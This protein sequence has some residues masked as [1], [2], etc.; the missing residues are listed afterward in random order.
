MSPIQSLF[1]S[2]KFLLLLLDTLIAA[3]LYFGGRYLA[4]AAVEELTFLI[5]ILQPV[6]VALIVAIAWEDN[7]RRSNLPAELDQV[8]LNTG[9]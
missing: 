2:R 1:R 8:P 9:D 3:A 6:F 4:P 5:G 7:N